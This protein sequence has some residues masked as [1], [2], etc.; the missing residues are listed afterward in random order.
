MNRDLAMLKQR[1]A[2]RAES[3]EE[4]EVLFALL[5]ELALAYQNGGVKGV[6]KTVTRTVAQHKNQAET[7]IQALQE[8]L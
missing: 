6:T 1:L 7:A 2:Q 3:H 8:R 4:E 5:D